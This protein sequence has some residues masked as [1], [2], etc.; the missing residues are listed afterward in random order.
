MLERFRRY[1]RPKFEKRIFSLFFKLF[2]IFFKFKFQFLK[3]LK[4]GSGD[5]VKWN[6]CVKFHDKNVNG[7]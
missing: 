4:I 7:C 5:I 1:C 3:N 6:I 2:L